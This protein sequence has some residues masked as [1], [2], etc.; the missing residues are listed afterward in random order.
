MTELKALDPRTWSAAEVRL[1]DFF[2]AYRGKAVKAKTQ[3]PLP[4]GSLLKLK[5]FPPQ[6]DFSE[7]F[8]RYHQDFCERCPMPLAVR[9][10]DGPLNFVAAMPQSR[11]PPDVGPKTY[12]ALGRREERGEG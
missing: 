10:T 5:D 12:V 9:P 11:K 2:A 1:Q 4:P 6:D 7:V 3:Q 8:P